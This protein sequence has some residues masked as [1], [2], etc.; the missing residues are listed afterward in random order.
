MTLLTNT[1]T[2]HLF[3]RYRPKRIADCVLLPRDR[4]FFESFIAKKNA[5]HLLLVGPP[6]VGKTSVAMALGNDMGWEVMQMN[7]A[8]Y[9]NVEAVRTDVSQFALPPSHI[10]LFNDDARHRCAF[11]DEFDH[12]P[13]K[14]QA[15]LRGVMERAAATG[16]CNFIFTANDGTKIDAAIR[17]RCAVFDFCYPDPNDQTI[18]T[19]GFRERMKM[20]LDAEGLEANEKLIDRLLGRY[21]LDFRAALNEVQKR[22]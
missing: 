18:I 20:I 3:E 5:P 10:P 1:A 11:L 8:A 7:A 21:G 16:H 13:S 22:I 4:K 19:E 15:A 2:N 14:A 17:S 6:G 12:M 9:G